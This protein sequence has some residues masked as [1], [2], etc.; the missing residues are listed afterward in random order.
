M[1]LCNKNCKPI[2]FHCKNYEDYLKITN[3]INENTIFEYEGL[4]KKKNKQVYAD[5]FC[6]DSFECFCVK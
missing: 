6:I 5:N 4:C 3:T 1:E 2:C